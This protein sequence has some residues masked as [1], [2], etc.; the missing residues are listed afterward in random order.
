MKVRAEI[1]GF[2]SAVVVA[3]AAL[4]VLAT[5]L[6]APAQSAVRIVGKCNGYWRT[7]WPS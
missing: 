7:G 6:P 3:V 1:S 4:S 2:Q 5:A